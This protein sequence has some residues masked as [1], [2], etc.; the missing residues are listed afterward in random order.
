MNPG[1]YKEDNNELLYAPNAVYGSGFVLVSDLKDTYQLPID[2][3]YWF[4]NEEEAR[5]I[6]INT[7]E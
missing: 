2:G 4:D 3:W 7:K 5:Q 6:L 1:F